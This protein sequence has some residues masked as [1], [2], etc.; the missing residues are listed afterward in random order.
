MSNTVRAEIPWGNKRA[1]RAGESARDLMAPDEYAECIQ[2]ALAEI[3][4]LDEY[5][6]QQS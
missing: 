5:R 3:V 4:S 2:A 6:E 1:L